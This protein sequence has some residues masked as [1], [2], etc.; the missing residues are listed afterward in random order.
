MKP[1]GKGIPAAKV[2]AKRSA[3]DTARA[4]EKPVKKRKCLEDLARLSDSLPDATFAI[5]TEGTVIIWNKAMAS[6]TGM[7]AEEMIGRRQ[8]A[9][10]EAFYGERR[11]ML[12]DLLFT[13]DEQAEKQYDWVKR[14]GQTITAQGPATVRGAERYLHAKASLLTDPSGSVIGAI[15]T[16]RDITDWKK[17]ELA[18]RESE[19][20]YRDIFL[21]VSDL[22]YLHD[23]NGRFME[24]NLA[25]KKETGY[26]EKDLESLRVQDILPERHRDRFVN[27]LQNVVRKGRDEGFFTI[28]TKDG[29]ERIIEYRNSL[30]RDAYG[31]PTAVRGIARDITQ[32]VTMT[33]RLRRERDLVKTIIQTSPAFFGAVDVNGSVIMINQAMLE[34][35]GYREAEV[36]GRDYKDLF[37]PREERE[38]FDNVLRAVVG[39][40]RPVVHETRLTAK[41]GGVLVVEWRSCAV[42]KPD[43]TPEFVFGI[44]IDVTEKRKAEED[45][46]ERRRQLETLVDNLPG[47]AY[48]CKNDRD[49][50]MD[51]VGSASL[52]LTGYTPEELV[53]NKAVSY[54]DLIHPDDREKVWEEVQRSL[55]RRERFQ[56]TYRIVTKDGRTLKVWEQGQG[57]FD[58]EGNVQSI[59][60]FIMDVTE[61]EEAQEE[62]RKSEERYRLLARNVQDVIWVLDLDLNHTYVSPSVE[63]MRGFTVE[64]VLRQRMDEVLTPESYAY[65]TRVFVEE[66]E[67]ERSGVQ[68]EAHWSRTI[69]L[70]LW[71]KDGSTLWTEVT[72]S[73]LRDDTGEVIGVVGITRDISE[74][75]KLEE[76][77]AQVQFAVEH[78]AECAF[79]VDGEGRII[80]V[81]EAACASLGY[82]KDELTRMHMPDIHPR[83]GGDSWDRR[84]ED[85]KRQQR[86]SY[87][88]FLLRK[89]GGVFP[90]EINANLL[91]FRGRQF[92]WAFARD[93]TERKEAERALR[94]SEERFR[95]MAEAIPMM[96]FM[97]TPSFDGLIYV[98]PACRNILGMGEDALRGNPRAWMDLV[99]PDDRAF[100]RKAVNED[101][102]RD[103]ALEFRI[104]RPDGSWG[105]IHMRLTPVFDAQG[106][107][108][109]RVGTAEDITR[110]KEMEHERE[111]AQ[112][113]L[114]RAGRLEAIGTLAGGIAHDFNN[115]LVAILGYAELAIEELPENNLA[116]ENIA[117]VL[118]AGERA[119]DLIRQ[120]LTFSRQMENERRQIRIQSVAKEVLKFLRASIPSTVRIE[121]HLD[122][123]AG[124]VNAD[125]V[126][127]HRIILNLCTN[128]Y[129]AMPPQGGLITV[130]VDK[131]DLD[132]ESTRRTPGL[133]PGPYVAVTVSDTGCG[134]D[135]HTMKRIFDPFFTTKEKG[136]GTG[137][138]LATVHGIVSALEGTVTVTSEVGR[139]ST[140]VVYL[141][142]RGKEPETQ[143][144]S[145]DEIPK[146]DGETVLVVDDE[147]SVLHIATAMLEQAGYRVVTAASGMEALDRFEECT[148]AISCVVT[149]QTMP[150]ITGAEL[151]SQLLRLRPGL[152]VILMTGFSEL[153]GRDEA[154]AMGIREYLDK[155]FTMGVLARAVKR[156]LTGG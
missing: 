110:R 96:F 129:Q 125:P 2:T 43:G 49:W 61:V 106:A 40:G 132:E 67:R 136:K 11:P 137:L 36:L 33:R 19:A 71:K 97:V 46:A 24:T 16:I 124:F 147:E 87:E 59:E 74:R 60:G 84:W 54:A 27:Y 138:G 64:E 83:S 121:E 104:E 41:N 5:D 133:A 155:P 123:D 69:E 148:E 79:W 101:A 107:P 57:V 98:N 134:M 90:V 37:L 115:I 32:R 9:H 29:T 3:A 151:A 4:V 39:T 141:P 28:V 45:L 20:K 156:C 120:I 112:A 12:V 22:V 117:E 80:Y 72:A 142:M 85:L 153:I 94:E 21:N 100:V 152:P 10:A 146:G 70:E 50:T 23:L 93:I 63:R 13:P 88:T 26:T 75:K 150:G 62:L 52:G 102:E 126:Q 149:D 58:A 47:M 35:L 109:C 122:P 128:A 53:H 131:V 86:L 76:A 82:T 14:E 81:N 144:H 135:E 118:K 51:F 73:P 89:D 111:L 127:I 91:T 30:V 116:R 18:L 17:A 44:G 6:L 139:G 48:R 140:F 154:L 103:A 68:R 1:R 113:H 143:D 25:A 108:S 99:H 92:C 66:L 78:I 65:A 38:S 119:R 15:E 77:I 114:E 105:W 42:F 55:A 56:I 7:Q 130:R 8:G 145:V 31:R 95:R 34:A